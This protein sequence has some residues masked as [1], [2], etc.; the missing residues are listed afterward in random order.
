M[1][2]WH[3]VTNHLI[4]SSDK[5]SNSANRIKLRVRDMGVDFAVVSGAV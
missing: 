3:H 1:H 2:M 5:D 4:I